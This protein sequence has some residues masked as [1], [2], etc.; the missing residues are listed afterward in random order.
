M[1]TGVCAC[2]N[3]FDGDNLCMPS[4]CQWEG[5]TEEQLVAEIADPA[6]VA[7]A[8]Q[9]QGALGKLKAA[10]ED[11]T[12]ALLLNSEVAALLDYIRAGAEL[13]RNLRG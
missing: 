12:N 8:Q 5:I 6:M 13:A 3:R 4:A 9:F 2:G 10:A 1:A 11:G 7:F